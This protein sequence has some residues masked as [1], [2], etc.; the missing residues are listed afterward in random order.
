MQREAVSGHMTRN[1]AGVEVLF[2]PGNQTLFRGTEREERLR[3]WEYLRN[4]S[5]C[6]QW[7]FVLIKVN[8]STLNILYLSC[9]RN[10]KDFLV[11][12]PR[13]GL[14]TAL[15]P[16]KKAMEYQRRMDVAAAGRAAQ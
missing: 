2:P 8:S 4:V 10:L 14:N 11:I 13:P 7:K 12:P 15:L 6:P 3:M 5:S 16:P 1:N 9:F